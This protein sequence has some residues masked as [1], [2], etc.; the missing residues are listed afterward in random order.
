MSLENLP[1]TIWWE[2]SFVRMIDQSR[3]PL[4]GDVLECGTYEGVCWAI[5]GLAVRGAPALG[6]AAA[7][8]LALWVE[9]Q[10]GDIDS[11]EDFLTDLDRVADEITQAR[12]TAVN[13]KW[14]AERMKALAHENAKLPLPELKA[15][16]LEAALA[17]QPRH[18]SERSRAAAG[19]AVHPHALQ[20]RLTGDG[21]LR[22][23]AGRGVRRRRGGQGAPRVG[24]RDAARASGSTPHGVGAD[25]RRDPVHAHHGQ[26]GRLGHAHR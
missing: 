7:L 21:V 15:K 2:D 14:G 10:A 6:V 16:I 18:R 20:R 17:M 25:A 12:P 24:R 9:N 11:V 13:L 4:V 22:Y 26:H 19:Q 3:L 5:K 23:G 8:A 1:R